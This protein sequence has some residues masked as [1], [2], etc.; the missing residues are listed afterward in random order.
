MIG[1][2]RIRYR[3]GL[4][5]YR[6]PPLSSS[7]YYLHPHLLRYR[8]HACHHSALDLDTAIA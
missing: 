8:T 1:S 2:M 3:Q 5:V 6:T 4:Q 7:Y